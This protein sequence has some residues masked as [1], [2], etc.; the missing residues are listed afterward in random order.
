MFCFGTDILMRIFMQF[1][2]TTLYVQSRGLRHP[3]GFGPTGPHR[4]PSFLGV[5]QM[6]EAGLGLAV[7]C[8]A[9]LNR[10]SR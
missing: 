2:G 7:L 5:S 8:E 6:R 1:G 3:V 9:C 4:G 10:Q